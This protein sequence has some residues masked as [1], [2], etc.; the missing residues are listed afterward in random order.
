M[1]IP[2]C[3]IS[4]LWDFNSIPLI[5]PHVDSPSNS[6]FSQLSL[7]N[8]FCIHYSPI[9]RI[10]YLVSVFSMVPLLFFTIHVQVVQSRVKENLRFSFDSCETKVCKIIS[11]PS[12]YVCPCVPHETFKIVLAK[13]KTF[14][15]MIECVACN[16]VSKFVLIELKVVKIN[17]VIGFFLLSF[18]LCYFDIH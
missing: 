4:Y 12:V 5:R 2:Y 10:K 6:L 8:G 15:P 13:I 17:K 18:F 9:D 16:F 3:S 11:F 7:S 1:A 14:S